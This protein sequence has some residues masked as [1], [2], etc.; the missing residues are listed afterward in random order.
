MKKIGGYFLSNCYLRD[1][2]Q[3]IKHYIKGILINL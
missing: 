2:K 3:E 1:Y